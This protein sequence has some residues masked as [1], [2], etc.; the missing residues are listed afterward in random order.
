M[1]RVYWKSLS[2]T[3]ITALISKSSLRAPATST[4]AIAYRQRVHGVLSCC[5]ASVCVIVATSSHVSC[6]VALTR[7][8]TR[9]ASRCRRVDATPSRALGGGGCAL[10]RRSV[11]RAEHSLANHL[12][13]FVVAL[14]TQRREEQTRHSL[15]C[16]FRSV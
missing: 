1:T 7:T 11:A 14:H 15:P 3:Q 2:F 8:H 10:A 5:R 13:H 12:T 16:A 6:V 4:F 9:R